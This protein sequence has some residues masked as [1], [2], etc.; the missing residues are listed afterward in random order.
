MVVGM[1]IKQVIKNLREV[2]AQEL[3]QLA[4]KFESAAKNGKVVKA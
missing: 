4:E 3:K 2:K 1:D